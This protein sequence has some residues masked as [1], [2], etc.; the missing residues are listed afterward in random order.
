MFLISLIMA[1]AGLALCVTTICAANHMPAKS[2]WT[3]SLLVAGTFAAAVGVV[4][5]ALSGDLPGAFKFACAAA[6]MMLGQAIWSVINGFKAT[7]L[8]NPLRSDK[9]AR[10][11]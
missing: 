7:R 5:S 4:V 11:H 10:Q 9:D 8:L 3:I 6:V 1:A 2:S